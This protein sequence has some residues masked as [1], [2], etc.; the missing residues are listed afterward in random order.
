M[1]W[2]PIRFLESCPSSDGACAV[3]ITDED[4]GKAAAADGRPPAW[5]LG[6]SSR[7]EPP[8]FPRRDPVRPQAAL[9]C[10][11]DVYKQA[12]ITRPREQID[13]AELYVPFSWHEPMW[14]EAHYLA[15]EGEGWKLTDAG[16]TEITGSMPINCSGGVLSS[17][18]IGASGPAAVRRG[19]AA[20]AGP[21]GRAPGRGGQ[22]GPRHGLRRQLAVLQHVGGGQQPPA[23]RLIHPPQSRSG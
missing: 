2:E 6:M 23:L 21:G 15:D 4:G 12:G 7:S 16:E 14:L 20:G 13:M 9:T 19:R 5:V 22:D 3:V 11:E 1:M 8:A 18:P 10:A 17:N